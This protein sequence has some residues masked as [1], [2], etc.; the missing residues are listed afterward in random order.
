L[1]PSGVVLLWAKVPNRVARPGMN[2]GSG[3]SQTESIQ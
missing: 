3:D 1:V 2:S